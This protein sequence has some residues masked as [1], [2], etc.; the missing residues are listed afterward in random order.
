MHEATPK[1]A[2]VATLPRTSSDTIDFTEVVQVLDADG[3]SEAVSARA[4]MLIDAADDIEA[5]R[6]WLDYHADS[7]H[8]VRAY[9]KEVLRLLLWCGYVGGKSLREMKRDDV[10][11]L[12]DFFAS[13]P[14]HW[15]G[16]GRA[17]R[18]SPEWR[19]F[20]GP[21]KTNAL[22]Q[23]RVVLH[24]LFD[25]LVD[26]RYLDGN[27]FA[28]VKPKKRAA[29]TGSRQKNPLLVETSTRR[30]RR[31]QLSTEALRFAFQWI[32]A[33]P[34]TTPMERRKKLRNEAVLLSF[35]YTGARL[36]EVAQANTGNLYRELD[37]WWL[38]VMG[39]GKKVAPVP[40]ATELIECIGRYRSA[41]GLP[42]Y[43][44]AHE[45]RPL[46]SRL[47]SADQSITDNMLYRI[48]TNI[49]NGAA[50]VA[51]EAGDEGAANQLQ[52]ASTHWLRHTTI[53]IT[54]NETGDIGLAQ[55]LARH[56][57]HDTTAKYAT[58]ADTT[59]HDQISEALRRRLV[60]HCGK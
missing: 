24:A 17:K 4:R 40:L 14:P 53:G 47:T 35:L 18:T 41:M 34:E 55:Q 45:D 10:A 52:N 49:L 28:L 38:M 37:R 16:S 51:N 36:F 7:P 13:P 19:P 30:V 44:A 48:V 26:A 22:H 12:L 9:R 15:I 6:S 56:G 25:W 20:Q 23:A 43:P 11:A 33:L 2:L 50:A 60:P 42:P 46:I 58:A 3:Q 5:V 59:L 31:H 29:A 57:S 1:A 8:T 54:V 32:Q 21:L 39:K 27:P